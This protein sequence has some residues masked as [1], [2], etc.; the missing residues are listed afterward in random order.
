MASGSLTS[1]PYVTTGVFDCEPHN[2]AQLITSKT[3]AN[4]MNTAGTPPSSKISLRIAY[5]LLFIGRLLFTRTEMGAQCRLPAAS[6]LVKFRQ[7]S[8]G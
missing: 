1:C 4:G 7:A 6:N 5:L 8:N 2:R 3:A